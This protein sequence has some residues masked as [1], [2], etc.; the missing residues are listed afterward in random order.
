MRPEHIIKEWAALWRK[1]GGFG[2]HMIHPRED[3]KVV[4]CEED[5]DRNHPRFP[6]RWMR[7]FERLDKVPAGL[8][9]DPLSSMQL[10]IEQQGS[11]LRWGQ[12]YSEGGPCNRP[13]KRSIHYKV[14]R[15]RGVFGEIESLFLGGIYLSVIDCWD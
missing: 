7:H 14:C 2:D 6:E 1:S 9:R 4:P 15:A 3:S 12:D 10:Q 8:L 11:V 5:R 13:L